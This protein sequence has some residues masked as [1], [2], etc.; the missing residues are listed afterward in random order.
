M[1]RGI[2]DMDATVD[3][4]GSRAGGILLRITGL[5]SLEM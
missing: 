2:T 1:I 3:K 4:R 5:G